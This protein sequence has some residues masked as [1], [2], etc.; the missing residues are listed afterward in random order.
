MGEHSVGLQYGLLVFIKAFRR[1]KIINRDA[2]DAHSF[3]D[4]VNL[5][6]GVISHRVGNHHTRFMQP[7]PAHSGAFLTG[8]APKHHRLFV[9][10]LHPITGKCAQFGHF[11][12]HHGDHV[13][14]VDFL[15]GI[16]ARD[17]GLHDKHTQFL[18]HTLDR[19]A[20]EGRIN[21]FPGFRHKAKALFRRRIGGVHRLPGPGHATHQPL[22]QFHPGLV[23]RLRAQALGGT[24]L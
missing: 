5:G 23:D 2:Q 12:Q 14:R 17:F 10:R 3:T 18:A 20:K 13:Q 7:D 6:Q 1:Q 16:A 4:P 9:K 15:F 22:T 21:L 24:K 8:A 11:G 19:H